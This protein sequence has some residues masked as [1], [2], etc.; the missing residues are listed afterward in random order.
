MCTF[1]PVVTQNYKLICFYSTK[2]IL[3]LLIAVCYII[4]HN[5]CYLENIQHFYLYILVN[6]YFG[7]EFGVKVNADL[8]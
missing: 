4:I 8:L 1:I 7:A 6:N 2:Y 3:D 5:L